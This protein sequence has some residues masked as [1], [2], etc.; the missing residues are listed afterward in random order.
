MRLMDQQTHQGKVA[1]HGNQAVGEMEAHELTE[2][3]GA[4]AAIAPRVVQV[5][6]EV[7]Q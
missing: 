3:C 7:M 1:N 2:P 4:V 5:P 6:H